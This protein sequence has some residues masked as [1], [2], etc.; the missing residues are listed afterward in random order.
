[1][2][3]LKLAKPKAQKGNKK[4][5]LLKQIITNLINKK[6]QLNK[7]TF[8]RY[9]IEQEIIG[10]C[11][12][13]DKRSIENKFSLLWRLGYFIQPKPN[14]YDVNLAKVSTLEEQLEET[15]SSV[16]IEHAHTFSDDLICHSK[17]KVTLAQCRY[18]KPKE[19]V[20][21]NVWHNCESC[22]KTLATLVKEQ[23]RS[24]EQ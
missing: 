9:E 8:T 12:V 21:S 19:N 13:S 1:M 24:K 22:I 14:E 23:S 16:G 5:K 6:Q 20:A 4:Q 17:R 7:Q 11:L 15:T 18:W 3:L 2:S 10:V